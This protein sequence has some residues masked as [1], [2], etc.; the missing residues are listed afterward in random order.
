METI[1]PASTKVDPLAGDRTKDVVCAGCKKEGHTIAQCWKEHP[2]QIPESIQKRRANG[3]STQAR[4]KPRS[5][6]SPDNKYQ[7]MAITYHRPAHT[8]V[9]SRKSIRVPV[10]A[11]AAREAIQTPRRV[12]FGPIA[13]PLYPTTQEEEEEEDDEVAGAA[14][15]P[16]TFHH[17]LPALSLE[18]GTT[19]L[20]IPPD[21]TFPD[22]PSM[23]GDP[24][25]G[26]NVFQIAAR[27]QTSLN[28]NHQL[29]AE[30]K[31]SI[32]EKT[33]GEEMP[34][35]REQELVTLAVAE[36]D[37]FKTH[38]T[39][40][41]LDNTKAFLYVNKCIPQQGII[42]TGAVCVIMSKRYAVA[43]GVNIST[44]VRGIEFI[45]ADGAL[46]TSLG[47]TSHPL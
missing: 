29:L 23:G 37:V 43:V 12:R 45:T 28:D 10:P 27:L 13:A 33:V 20:T 14:H 4:K 2:E 38:A 11:V 7:T 1:L 24:V 9:A 25:Q 31:A 22:Q 39:A 41:L 32:W 30:L 15:L 19:N 35:R 21:H 16:H 6:I 18:P 44:L 34:S 42:D 3:M 47:T 26:Q 17:A 40:V 46:A 36:K 8:A 5:Q